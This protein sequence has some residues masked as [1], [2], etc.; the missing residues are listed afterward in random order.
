[1]GCICARS[2]ESVVN[3]LPPSSA[4][5]ERSE[6]K[7][8]SDRCRVAIITGPT[9]GIG[10][11]TAKLLF[12]LGF[13]VIL[14]GRSEERLKRA[15]EEIA[16][17]YPQLDKTKLHVL[18]VDTSSFESV[19]SFA[20]RFLSLG[21]PLHLLINNAGIMAAP[22]SLTRDGFESQLQTNHL[23]HFLLTELLLPKMKETA[24]TAPAGSVRV[25]CVS[26]KAHTGAKALDP[27]HLN[28]LQKDYAPFPAYA[29]SKLCN[30]LHARALAE[31]L[32]G[33]GITAYSLHPGVI[34]TDLGRNNCGANCFYSVLGCCMLNTSQGSATTLYCAL[35]PGLEVYSGR[36]FSDVRLSTAS[37]LGEDVQL[38]R[39]LYEVS[40]QLVGLQAAAGADRTTSGNDTA[41]AAKTEEKQNLLVS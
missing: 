14:A 36:Y 33:T 11:Y 10:K 16:V 27:N 12:S 1:M 23:G 19:R 13:Q 34:R 5:A 22:F 40:L 17:A 37:P 24:A 4:G 9:T 25:I 41:A 3:A 7:K 26:S 2:A 20:D 35:E 8:D 38:A 29:R 32:Q 30:I 18:L 15:A 6:D 31:R 21:L 39:R 28:W